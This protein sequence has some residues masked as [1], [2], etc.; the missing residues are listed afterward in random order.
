[1]TMRSR[2][3]EASREILVHWLNRF[4]ILV[5]EHHRAMGKSAVDIHDAIG[6]AISALW[7]TPL[8]SLPE[9]VPATADGARD[10]QVGDGWLPIVEEEL[11]RFNQ[12]GT[13]ISRPL[14]SV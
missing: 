2:P 14:S 12:Y 7:S 3:T 6:K 8:D 13:P 1:M 4:D 9:R 10:F 5:R 11:F